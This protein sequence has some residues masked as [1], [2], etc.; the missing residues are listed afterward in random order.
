[1]KKILS[2]LV[3]FILSSSSAFGADWRGGAN[4]NSLKGTTLINDIDT[5]FEDEVSLQLDDLL[6]NYVQGAVLTYN[7]GVTVDITAGSLTCKD[8]TTQI[9]KMR[10]NTSSVSATFAGNLDSGSESGS[11]TYFVFANCDAAA[12]TFTIKISASS[13]APSGVTSYKR[14]GQFFN[15]SSSDITLVKNDNDR[16]IVATGTVSNGGT[17]SLPSGWAQDECDWI[18]TNGSPTGSPNSSDAISEMQQ[19]ATVTSSRVATCTR[20]RRFAGTTETIAN[21]CSYI[22][23]CYR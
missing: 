18:V 9:K 1:M 20:L 12:D 19:T 17:I 13:S 22:I 15:N 10:I 16:V 6:A 11:T 7:S 2:I 4:D 14:L 8:S 5:Q 3:I 23:T 21:T